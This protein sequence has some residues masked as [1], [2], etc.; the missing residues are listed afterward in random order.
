M[1][2]K[3]IVKHRALPKAKIRLLCFPFA[4]SGSSFYLSWAKNFEPDVEVVPIQLPGRENRLDEAPFDEINEVIAELIPVI[5]NYLDKPYAIFG[6]SMGAFLSFELAREIRRQNFSA[7]KILLVSA[8]RAAHLRDIRPPIAS[9]E[10]DRLIE[11]LNERYGLDVSEDSLEILQL[12]LPTIRAD[13]LATEK[14]VYQN[15]PPFEFP[16]VGLSGNLDSMVKSS[17]VEAWSH[18]TTAQFKSYE[19]DGG[20]FFI[21]S[22][23]DELIKY[24]YTELTNSA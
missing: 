2:S 14:Y 19:I 21:N 18:H 24:I 23:R 22:D 11:A 13:I 12:M 4:G 5:Q 7:P 9:L 8:M 17:E 3:W 1:N 15:E 10:D 16:I 6:H 20:H